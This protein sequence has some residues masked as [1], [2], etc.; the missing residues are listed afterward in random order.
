M[1][2]SEKS[3]ANC[4]KTEDKQK[5]NKNHQMKIYGGD[6][7]NKVMFEIHLISVGIIVICHFG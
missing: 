6:D 2:A 7:K 1:R 5:W 3:T 4:I